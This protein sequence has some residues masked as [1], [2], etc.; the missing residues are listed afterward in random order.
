[1]SDINNGYGDAAAGATFPVAIPMHVL[2][3]PLPYSTTYFMS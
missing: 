1:M 2:I 3:L